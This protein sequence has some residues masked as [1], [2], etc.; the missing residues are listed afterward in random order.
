M[1]LEQQLWLRAQH[2]RL[3]V[4]KNNAIQVP[5]RSRKGTDNDGRVEW[6]ELSEVA[7]SAVALGQLGRYQF[8][9]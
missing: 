8:L 3:V 7:L 2:C 9:S 1:D 4:Q 5:P 6:D